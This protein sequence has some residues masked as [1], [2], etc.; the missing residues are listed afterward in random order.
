MSLAETTRYALP[1]TFSSVPPYLEKNT[2]SPTAMSRGIRLPLSSMRPGP[3]ATTS[4]SCGFSLADSGIT[5]PKDVTS[6]A[7]IG[8]M[9]MRSSRG[10]IENDMLTFLVNNAS[11]SQK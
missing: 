2:R 9:M 11:I 10:L 8:R 1:S 6:S 5:S 7:A 4:A 3:S